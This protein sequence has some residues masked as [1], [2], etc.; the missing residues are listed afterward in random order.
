MP[1]PAVKAMQHREGP[2]NRTMKMLAMNS[3]E[4]LRKRIVLASSA[5]VL[6]VAATPALAQHMNDPDGP[7]LE[8][9]SMVDISNCFM[10]ALERADNELNETYRNIMAG[11]NDR[12]KVALR[13]AQRAWIA[14]RDKACAAEAEPYR[15]GSALGIVRL[16]C[17]EAATRARTAFMQKGLGWQA[18]HST[19]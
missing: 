8:A 9:G 7:C 18:P 13:D 3:S 17:L 6:G 15:G 16:A 14:Y 1:F 10:E 11:L 4:S 19:D 2:I 5:A 12:E